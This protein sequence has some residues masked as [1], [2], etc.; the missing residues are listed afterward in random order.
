MKAINYITHSTVLIISFVLVLISGQQFGGFYLLYIMLA[1]PHG[2]LH[3]I[4][5]VMGIA[6]LIFSNYKYKRQFSYLIEP[7]LNITGAALL[8]LSLFLFFYTD[9]GQYNYGT[10]YQAVP[11]ISLSIFG[12]LLIGFITNN[13]VRMKLHEAAL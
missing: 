11:I 4:L 10:F 1:L 7:L 3:A 12:L 5:A 6:V 9:K 13:L 2:G 8:F